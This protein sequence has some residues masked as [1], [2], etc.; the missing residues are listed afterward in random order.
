MRGP[1][2]ALKRKRTL[3]PGAHARTAAVRHCPEEHRGALGQVLGWGEVAVKGPARTATGLRNNIVSTLEF[4]H[5]S[6]A[7]LGK[8]KS[9]FSGDTVTH[10]RWG[11]QGCNF[12]ANV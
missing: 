3:S 4:L 9:S 1:G 11:H 8:Q 12:I 7:G 5:V 6:G 10:S 2:W